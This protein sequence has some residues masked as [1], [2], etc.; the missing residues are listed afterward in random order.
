MKV[1]IFP[2]GESRIIREVLHEENEPEV[3]NKPMNLVYNGGNVK[4]FFMKPSKL[5]KEAKFN[6]Q[7]KFGLIREAI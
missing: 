2:E 4:E 1:Q 5:Y 3:M 7:A 6:D